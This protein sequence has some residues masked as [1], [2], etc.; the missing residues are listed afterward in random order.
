MTKQTKRSLRKFILD[1][2]YD[3]GTGHIIATIASFMFFITII[4]GY[5]RIEYAIDYE[6]G[7]LTKECTYDIY[8]TNK[9]ACIKS[10][11]K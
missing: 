11:Y 9:S 7:V 10:S 8:K 1:M 3:L 2:K 4:F 6:L 5:T